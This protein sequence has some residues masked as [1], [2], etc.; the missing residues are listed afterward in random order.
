[1]LLA[2]TNIIGFWWDIKTSNIEYY[3]IQYTAEC[4]IS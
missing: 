3:D 2:K 1:M 4:T